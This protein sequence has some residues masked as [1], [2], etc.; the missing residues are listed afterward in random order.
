MCLVWEIRDRGYFVARVSLVGILPK[1]WAALL[2]FWNF[3]P[4]EGEVILYG[5][6]LG[7]NSLSRAIS[8]YFYFSIW[9]L[10]VAASSRKAI[11]RI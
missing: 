1:K 9:K 11:V 3:R 5:A 6:K 2:K 10:Y 7:L 8:G 4:I